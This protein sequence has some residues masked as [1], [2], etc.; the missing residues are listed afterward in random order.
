[1][2]TS[3]WLGVGVF[4]A[5]L[6]IP[7]W[8]GWSLSEEERI[9]DWEQLSDADGIQT[10]RKVVPG[11][12]LVAFKGQGLIEAP[13]AKVAQIIM[14]VQRSHEWVDHV[15][16]DKLVERRGDLE[17][18]VYTRVSTPPIIMRDRDFVTHVKV[19]VDRVKKV[20]S[21]DIKSVEDARFPATS[22]YVRGK[23]T[24]GI[25]RLEA[26]NDGNATFIEGEIEASPAGSVPAWVVNF[27]QKE[28]GRKTIQALRNQV[29]KVDIAE[30]LKIKEL[31]DPNRSVASDPAAPPS[32]LPAQ[33]DR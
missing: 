14:D 22:K 5:V 31:L 16:D 29:K 10:F 21:F 25:F 27:F 23:V 26:R 28:W 11:S 30:N 1:M 19:E 24:R 18:R 2:K 20:V 32:A 15:D 8:S 12:P 7:I 4:F 3:S 33:R 17:Y 6:M 13:V 9:R